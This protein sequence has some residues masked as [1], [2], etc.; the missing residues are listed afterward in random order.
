MDDCLLFFPKPLRVV[1]KVVN[2][3]ARGDAHLLGS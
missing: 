2:P 1:G 3:L